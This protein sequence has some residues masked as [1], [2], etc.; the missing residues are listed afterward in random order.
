[1]TTTTTT[2][3][4]EEYTDTESYTGPLGN[5]LEREVTK[6]REIRTYT[7]PTL[8]VK[9]RLQNLISR[10]NALEADE[11]SDDATSSALLTIIASLTARVDARDAV[12]ADLTTRIQSLEGG[13]N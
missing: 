2:T 3:T 12:I 1:M 10:M 11:I 9:E 7:G 5:T 13:N 6:T 8:E 4:T